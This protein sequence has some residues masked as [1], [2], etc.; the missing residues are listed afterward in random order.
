MSGQHS[1]QADLED[2]VAATDTGGRQPLGWQA[3][4]LAGIALLWSLFQIYYASNIPFFLTDLTGWNVTLNSDS[5][6]S[7]HLSFAM[8]LAALSYPLTPRSPRDRIPLY[9]W[10]LAALGVA[11]CMYMVVF[12]D[13]IAG[14]AGLP[15]TADLVMSTI[16]MALLLLLAYRTLGLPMVLVG[17]VF[18]LYVFFGDS[19][20]LPDVMQWKGA[21]YNKAMWHFWM[22]TEGVFGIALGVSTSMIF[23]FVLFGALL[24]K[25]GAGHY[26]V[27]VSF[28]LLGHLRGGPA[29]AAVLSSALTGVVSGS[30]IANT[31]T[32]GTFTIPLMR[33]VGF[34]R[35]KAG[36]VE[37]ASSVNGQLMPPV[38]GAA[39]F[40][41]VEYV[42]ISYNEV[43]RHAV[44]PAIISY[45]A[46]V[47][48]VHLEAC[49]AGMTGLPKPGADR[50]LLRRLMGLVGGF[51]V[52]GGACAVIYY[53]LEWAKL[54]FGDATF[55]VVLALFAA[56]YI[57][58][59]LIA[60]MRPD[61]ELDDPNAPIVSLPETL[62]TALTGLYYLLPLVVLVWCLM[63]ERFSPGLSA[64]WAMVAMVA[65]L[66]THRMLKSMFRGAVNIPDDMG[67]G[68]RDMIDGLIAGARNMT[69]IALATAVAGIIVGTISLT[70][71]QQIMGELIEYLAGGSLMAMLVLVAVL[72]IVLGMGLPTT[73][74]YIVVSSLMAFV[75]VDVGAQNGLIVPLIAVHMFVFYFG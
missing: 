68:F 72:S 74:N 67:L 70:G 65:I 8:V 73:A 44:L 5:A 66:L 56:A 2:L 58:L 19:P 26:F 61:L 71:M 10:G 40:L 46:L 57:G 3:K 6:R 14:R 36:A 9:D 38:M 41:M 60:A 18:L 50:P 48:I 42:G 35:E 28:A 24:E 4:A 69:G 51:G 49:K 64:F 11:A 32:T 34:S 47:Y 43:I 12:S 27:Q 45:L 13:D 75:I 1:T 33:R 22:Q 21:S 15:T 30:S 62:P 39:A 31:V 23:L 37:V 59:L 25:A 16:G 53:V 17:V 7:I 54:A 29:K 20:I 63:I 52:F 55:W